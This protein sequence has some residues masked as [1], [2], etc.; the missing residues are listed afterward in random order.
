M[1]RLTIEYHLD[2]R[3][4]DHV[5]V[6]KDDGLG[7]MVIDQLHSWNL[8]VAT[9]KLPTAIMDSLKDV[10]L[11]CAPRTPTKSITM[12]WEQALQTSQFLKETI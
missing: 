11:Y 9:H 6:L 10:Y 8:H 2:H 5:L 3:T 4:M 1:S 7:S 12:T